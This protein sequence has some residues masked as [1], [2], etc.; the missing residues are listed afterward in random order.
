MR[1]ADLPPGAVIMTGSVVTAVEARELHDGDLLSVGGTTV[2]VNGTDNHD[3]PGMARIPVNYHPYGNEI[4]R[5]ERWTLP[6]TTRLTPQQL[7]RPERIDCAAC[8][9][10]TNRHTVLVDRVTEGWVQAWVCDAHLQL[11]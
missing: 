2:T 11:P 10:G 1:L 6:A 9:P 7:L 4:V 5:S 3:L 8:E